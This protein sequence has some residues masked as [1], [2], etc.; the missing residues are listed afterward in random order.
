MTL[1]KKR[2]TLS[3]TYAQPEVSG[4]ELAALSYDKRLTSFELN[5][6][7]RAKRPLDIP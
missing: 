7:G 2:Q 1:Q 4:G 5:L 6:L 3:G